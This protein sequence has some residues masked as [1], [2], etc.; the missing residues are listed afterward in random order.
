[1]RRCSSTGREG[2]CHGCVARSNNAGFGARWLRGAHADG[3]RPMHPQV[4]G[5]Y[6]ALAGQRRA[7]AVRRWMDH[8]GKSGVGPQRLHQHIAAL[9]FFY[10]KTVFRP[11]AVSFLSYPTI[12][13]ELRAI[14]KYRPLREVTGRDVTRCALCGGPLV[15]LVAPP[16]LARAPPP[17]RIV[18]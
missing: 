4:C 9:R 2:G 16:T 7:R 13:S 11:D 3:V 5:V 1:M 17:M 6:G 18:A 10:R 15:R 14:A 12:P 8:L